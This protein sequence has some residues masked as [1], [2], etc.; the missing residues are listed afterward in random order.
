[1][2]PLKEKRGISLILL[3]IIMIIMTILAGTIILTLQNTNPIGSATEAG[4][5]GDMVAY[6]DEFNAYVSDQKVQSAAAGQVYSPET[7]PNLSSVTGQA[8]VDK[9]IIEKM[10]TEYLDKVAIKDG[11]F[12]YVGKVQQE[13]EWC[14]ELGIEVAK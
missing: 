3:I 13:R 5:K 11:E 8:I 4:F 7:D 14:T 1:M 12:V 9:G 6:R 10:K 2:H